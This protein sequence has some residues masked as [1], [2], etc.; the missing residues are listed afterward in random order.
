MPIDASLSRSNASQHSAALSTAES[1]E[2]AGSSKRLSSRLMM[3]VRTT[4]SRI[5]T[6]AASLQKTRPSELASRTLT[7][8][9]KEQKPTADTQHRTSSASTNR[10]QPTLQRGIATKRMTLQGG[11]HFRSAGGFFVKSPG[12]LVSYSTE[13]DVHET[14]TVNVSP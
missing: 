6:A 1:S 12:A 3:L 11:A 9:A 2:S 7:N 5:S 10:Q 8:A 14:M 13:H 4:T